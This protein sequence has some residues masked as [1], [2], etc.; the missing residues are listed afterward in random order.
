MQTNIITFQN[1]CIVLVKW[2]IAT[3]KISPEVACYVMQCNSS[4]KQS[5]RMSADLHY[6]SHSIAMEPAD[7]I[8]NKKQCF[9]F[10]GSC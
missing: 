2:K 10:K 8:S 4:N 9:E 6:Q 7:V 3:T 5:V 1:N